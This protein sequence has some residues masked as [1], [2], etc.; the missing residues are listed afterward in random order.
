[1]AFIGRLAELRELASFYEA[2]KEENLAIVYGRLRVGKSELLRESLDRAGCRY[3]YFVCRETSERDNVRSLMEVAAR[4]TGRPPYAVEK[5]EPAL[6]TLFKGA[7]GEPTVLVL[8][9][10]PYLRDLVKH[11]D[12][13]LASLLDRWRGK[14]TLKIVL[15]GSEVGVMRGL[16]EHE[17]PLFSRAR[18]II[19]LK[20][21]DYFD[22][23]K[24]HPGFSHEDNVRLYSVFGGIPWYNQLIDPG[25]SVKENIIGLVASRNAP[26]RDEIA[27]FLMSGFSKPNNANLALCELAGGT[28]KF[29]DILGKSRIPSSPTLADVLKKLSEMEL[30]SKVEPI[31]SEGN[32]R[33]AGYRIADPLAFF[34]YRYLQCHLSEFAVMAPD[35]FWD[36]FVCKDFETEYVPH[37]FEEVCRQFLLRRNARRLM[38]PPFFR[39]GK[40]W[41]DLPKKGKKGE[42]DMVT[43]DRNGYRFYEA[44]FRESPMT[45]SEVEKEILQVRDSPLQASRFGFISR[46]GFKAGIGP[47]KDL[48]LYSLPALFSAELDER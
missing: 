18:P 14:S 42:F 24:F 6:E 40:Y 29:S 36:E 44:K 25:K 19:H 33:R 13:I 46:S 47:R 43:E 1:M 9:E 4:G 27:F 20:P 21:M 38:A 39:I 7:A 10:Y 32:P 23:A 28:A 15:C 48:A 22:A 11:A 31:N 16:A 3:V 5:I 34:Y 2:R 30:V 26:L 45:S 35:A 12:S 8:D 41:Y 37:A 17:S